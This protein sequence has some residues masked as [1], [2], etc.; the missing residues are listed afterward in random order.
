MGNLYAATYCSGMLLGVFVYDGIHLYTHTAGD[1]KT[2]AWLDNL[3]DRHMRH[4]YRNKHKEFGVTNS[5]WDYV[6]D[7]A[8][9]S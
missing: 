4:H 5:F 2:W 3:K 1:R 7:T 9:D 6:F 8:I